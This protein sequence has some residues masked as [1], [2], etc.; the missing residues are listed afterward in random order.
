MKKL[1]FMLIVIMTFGCSNKNLEPENVLKKYLE[2]RFEKNPNKEELLKYV[3]GTLV[4]EVN[5][6][7]SLGSLELAKLQISSVK[8]EEGKCSIIYVITTKSDK[9]I[10]DVKKVATLIQENK[11]WKISEVDNIK[12]YHDMKEPIAPLQ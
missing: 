10:T 2:L 12:T 11:I 4:D 1:I 5:N 3:T 8:C 9:E 7:Q 6:S